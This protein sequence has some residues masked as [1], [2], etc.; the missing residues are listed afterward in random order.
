MIWSLLAHEVGALGGADTDDALEVANFHVAVIE[1]G[2]D[3][4]SHLIGVEV[5]WLAIEVGGGGA[6]ERVQGEDLLVGVSD[7]ESWT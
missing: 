7:F 1:E 3:L 4:A 5:D 2:S 6:F